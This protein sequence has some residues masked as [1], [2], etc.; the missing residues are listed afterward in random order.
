MAVYKRTDRTKGKLWVAE[1]NRKGL[2]PFK[3]SFELEADASRWHREQQREIDMKGLPLT[4]ET[5]KGVT[6]GAIIERYLKEVTPTKASK[7]NEAA[8]LN[9]FLR[10]RKDLCRKALAYVTPTDAYTYRNQRLKDTWRGEPIT[11]RT[12]AREITTLRHAFNVAIEEWGYSNLKNP[13][14]NMGLNGTKYQRKRRLREGELERL[15][16]AAKGCLGLNRIYV[17]LAVHLAIETGMR[18]QEIFNLR[19]QDID[20]ARR[21]IEITKSKTD[22]QTG[23]EGRTIVLTVFAMLYLLALNR[24]LPKKPKQ[25]DSIFP[26]TK[27]AF[28][29]SW[30]DLVKRAEIEDLEF[31]DLR[32]EAGSW[33][34]EAGL[35]KAENE[36]MLG[37]SANDTNSIYINSKLKP[38]QDKLDRHVLGGKS[39]DEL[40]AARQSTDDAT[41][42]EQLRDSLGMM[43]RVE[44]D[45]IAK[46]A[47]KAFAR[48]TDNEA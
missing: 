14:G 42:D 6:V 46:L 22:S 24:S 38:I 5:L 39:L 19:W 35:T 44:F 3:K 20:V 18:M 37:H 12:V 10:E 47:P 33:F 48:V 1:I 7:V 36:L 30:A 21:Q 31:R 25:S 45:L 16:E 27:G 11:T 9:K 28:G 40:M 2:P 32:R 34:D 43:N 26:M 13:F 41:R 15:I 8:V 23:T 29:Q 17:P 4:I